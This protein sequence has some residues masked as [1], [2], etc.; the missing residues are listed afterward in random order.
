MKRTTVLLLKKGLTVHKA[1]KSELEKTD[2]VQEYL[3]TLAALEDL[4]V[5]LSNNKIEE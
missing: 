1:R 3:N 2:E 5:D 4:Y